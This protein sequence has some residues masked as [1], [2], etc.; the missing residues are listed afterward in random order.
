MSVS[1][2]VINSQ[3]VRTY[4]NIICYI[5]QYHN[6]WSWKLNTFDF[7]EA[8]AVNDTVTVLL[9]IPQLE[10]R[11]RMRV[12]NKS[13]ENPRDGALSIEDCFFSITLN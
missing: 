6:K 12:F 2:K 4:R 13:T 1:F 7:I 8:C 9:L 10:V 5:A 3:I 11:V